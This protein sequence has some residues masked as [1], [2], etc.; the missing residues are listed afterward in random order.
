MVSR[1]NSISRLQF[2]RSSARVHSSQPAALIA[3]LS[4]LLVVVGLIMILS[5]SSVTSFANYGSSFLFFKR[6][7]LWAVAGMALFV[8]FCRLDYRRLKGFGYVLYPIALLLLVM[9]LVPGIG[10]TVGG[11]TRW[12]ALGAFSFQPSEFAKLALVLLSADVFSRKQ[13]S[14]LQ[15]PSHMLLPMVPAMGMMAALV[16]RQP[17]LGT[18]LLL[19]AIGIGMLFLA[20]SPLRFLV[21]LGL[22]GV[23]IATFAALSAPY[24]RERVLA[25]MDPWADPLRTGYHTIQSLIALGSGGWLGVGLGASRQKWMYIP[26]AH[27]D[28]IFAILG[29]EMGA[30]GTVAVLGMFA[31]LAFLGLKAARRAP[32]RFGMLLA[33]GIVIWISVQTLVNIGA[34]T[35]LLPVTGVPLPLLSFGGSSLV[36]S[37]TAMGILTNIAWQGGQEQSRPAQRSAARGRSRR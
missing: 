15:R 7:L 22:A 23:T 21:P 13:E 16:L 27:T 5:A 1:S 25:F 33:S 32:D 29:E 19:G 17:D 31:L 8:L 28:F 34:V 9:T 35:A 12:I 24:R 36:L 20:G 3:T 14:L 2:A 30:V 11:G 6:Q 37:L 18:T 10:V 26:N 4:C